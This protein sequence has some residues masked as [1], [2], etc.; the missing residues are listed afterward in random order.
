MFSQESIKLTINKDTIIIS[1]TYHRELFQ[2]DVF[3]SGLLYQDAIMI[4]MCM[5]D[6]HGKH[7]DHNNKKLISIEEIDKCGIKH[8][9]ITLSY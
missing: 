5:D 2:H 4:N 1:S 9:V 6:Y 8:L 7:I 3:Y